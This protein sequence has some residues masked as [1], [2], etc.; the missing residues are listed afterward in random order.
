MILLDNQQWV[1]K[2]FSACE[3]N[4]KRRTLRMKVVAKNM[5]ARPDG[6]LPTQNQDWSDLKAAYR[7]FDR[8]EVTFEAVTT[9]HWEQTKNTK[10]GRYLLISDTTDISLYNHKATTGLGMLGDGK[11]RGIQLH[12]CLM[13]N[14]DEK[15]IVGQAGAIL[16]YRKPAPKNEKRMARLNRRR[17]SSLW[18][19]LVDQVG[20]APD[21]SQWIHVFDRGGDNFES[22]CHIKQTGDDWV[23][24]ASKLNRRVI[25]RNG[26]TRSLKEATEEGDVLG[27]Y[28]LNLRS[29][30]GVAA[31]TAKI[32]VSSTSVTFPRPSQFS[33]WVR[34]SG[35]ND[36]SMN[37]VV[38]QEVDPPE[39]IKP[40]KW[41][42]LTSLPTATFEQ[43]WQVIEDYENRW[44]IEE[45]HKV[46]KTG[47]GIEKH[48]LQTAGRT[49]ALV[50]LISVI[51]TRLFQLK[52]IGRNQPKALA[53]THVLPHWLRC[54]QA[55]RPKLQGR[56]LT[57]YEFFRELAKMGG[58]IGRKGDG[59]PGWMTIWRGYRE[60]T[61]LLDGMRLA[62]Q[63]R[64]KSCG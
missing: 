30:P 20:S 39:G 13:Y 56:S 3:F 43:A 9:P 48:A 60:L 27:S 44:L 38:V 45:Y 28:D 32:E 34:E 33:T 29:R 5:L 22:I 26:Q 42:L 59:E 36:L 25:D 1:E 6:S 4:H 50:G 55:A 41:V 19:E 54:M 58:F 49:E 40:I 51:G 52:L 8:P 2:N 47:C 57:V 63:T 46:L 10:P 61:L 23:I 64:S 11:G 14:S 12:N 62:E 7:L 18:D 53:S 16:F 21:G 15:Q 24:R 35:I 31:R 37:V 17:E